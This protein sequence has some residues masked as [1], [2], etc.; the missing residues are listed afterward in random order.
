MAEKRQI[1][2]ISQAEKDLN[3]LPVPVSILFREALMLIAEGEAPDIVEGIKAKP[4]SDIGGGKATVMELIRRH[5]TNTFRAVYTAKIGKDVYVLH[6]FMKK[7][8]SGIGLPKPD[9]KLIER[10]LKT[11]LELIR[12][13][14]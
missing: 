4:L 14:S 9:K 3:A 2:F 11:A 5:D 13:E 6:C 7:S 12:N 8:K 1:I 10:R